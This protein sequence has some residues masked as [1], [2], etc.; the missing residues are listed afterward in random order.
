MKSKNKQP[1]K[2]NIDTLCQTK[3]VGRPP[4]NTTQQ[5]IIDQKIQDEVVSRLSFEGLTDEQIN[6]LKDTL[7]DTLKQYNIK[8]DKKAEKSTLD[9]NMEVLESFLASKRVES[10][11]QTTIYNYGN[12]ISKMFL[13]LNKDYR[14]ITSE[15]IRKYMD[16]RKIHDGLCD[17]SIHNI[18]MY[19]MS[20]FKFLTVEEKIRKNPMD[21]IGVVKK[22]KKVVEY[23][24]DE[25]L[26]MIRCSAKTERDIALI[27]VLSGSGMRVSELVGLNISDVDF[28]KGEMKVFGKGGKERICY[29]TGRAK[30]HLRWY[31]Q[32]RTD[33]IPALFVTTKKPYN[34][35][36]KNGVEYALKE[37][38]ANSKIPEVRLYPHRFRKTLATQMINRGADI[39]H[40]QQILG[41]Q[42]SDTT[43]SC[44]TNISNDTVKHAHHQYVS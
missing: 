30:V 23:L 20:F 26:E 44:Y 39:S 36:S 27:D 40:I 33:D 12:E 1:E 34:R 25:E 29:L 35:L 2:K 13:N 31:L 21:K 17:T 3:R 5:D 41:H 7:D 42:S 11:S 4:K 10:K 32:Q 28:D 22:T 6:L 43:I 14:E 8:K 19:L 16:Y 24:T 38:S 37:I 9:I 18:R 15:D